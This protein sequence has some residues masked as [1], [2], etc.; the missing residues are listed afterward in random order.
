[1][2]ARFFLMF[3]AFAI[4]TFTSCNKQSDIDQAGVDMANDDAVSDAIFE[5]VFNTVDHA[6][7]ILDSYQKGGYTKSAEADSCPLVTI[8]HPDDAVW[9]KT[10]TIDFGT[11]C[12]GLY[13]N[14]R[15]GK[16]LIVVTG[17]RLHPG[18]TRTVTFDNYHVNGIKVEGTKVIENLGYNNNQNMVFSATLTDGKLTLEDGR[19]IER[20]FS[21]EREWIAGLLTRNIWDDECLITGTANGVTLKGKSYSNTIITAL[22]WKRVCRF[23]VS[24]VV[25]IE[26]E[27][28]EPVDLNYGDG[29]CDANA[30][31]TM[32][33]K[34]KEI[35]LKYH[36]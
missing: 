32:G 14:T 10:I 2:K 19:T 23:L 7:I 12:T 29:E 5:D 9:P 28:L 15:S 33:D 13:D 4:F 25:R 16:I 26:R 27:G 34:V 24:G 31:L 8:D 17:P 22:H 30:T 6:D 20:S 18:T 11:L 3:A 1:M 35:L 36:R 21:H